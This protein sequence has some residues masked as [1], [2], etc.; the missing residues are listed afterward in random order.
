MYLSISDICAI[1]STHPK[2]STFN[3]N[4][5]KQQHVCIFFFFFRSARVLHNESLNGLAQVFTKYREWARRTSPSLPHARTSLA[6]WKQAFAHTGKWHHGRNTRQ[7]LSVSPW[8]STGSRLRQTAMA[9]SW[10]KDH[11]YHGEGPEVCVYMRVSIQECVLLL[12]CWDTIRTL[13][14]YQLQSSFDS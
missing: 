6:Y 1:P 4:D 13:H 2:G 7:A 12:G 10:Q 11:C 5:Y 8:P 3:H 14:S 9:S